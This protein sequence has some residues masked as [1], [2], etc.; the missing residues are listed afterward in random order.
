MQL[1]LSYH[2]ILGT[3]EPSTAIVGLR[4]LLAQ[5]YMSQPS[6]LYCVCVGYSYGLRNIP[7]SAVCPYYSC[8]LKDASY[9]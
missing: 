1:W 9:G 4:F 7:L 2:L 5:Q 6:V 8:C 3:L